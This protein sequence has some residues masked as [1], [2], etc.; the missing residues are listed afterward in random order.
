[1]RRSLDL[2]SWEAATDLVRAWEASGEIGV[3]KPEVPTIKE[4]VKKFLAADVP[5]CGAGQVA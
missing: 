2:R 3:V 1:M 4:A 5:A